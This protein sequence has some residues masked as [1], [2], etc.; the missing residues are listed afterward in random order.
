RL[1]KDIVPLLIDDAGMPDARE[2]PAWLQ[3]F[4]LNQGV[5]ISSSATVDDIVAKLRP[6]AEAIA[7]VRKFG[8]GWV[9]TYALFALF[10]W[11]TAAIAT[12]AI[13]VIEFG[14]EAWVGLAAAWSGFFIWPIFFFPLILVALYRP[15]QT[16]VE[17]ALNAQSVLDRLRYLS[18]ILLGFALACVVT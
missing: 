3:D 15:F 2:L 4:P 17:A 8:P 18:P 12:N 13:G 7:A 5:S 1:D 9:W 16:L 11:A 10:A 6:R 14:I